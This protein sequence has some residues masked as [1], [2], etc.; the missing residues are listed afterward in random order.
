NTV[1]LSSGPIF[2]LLAHPSRVACNVPEPTNTFPAM[3]IMVLST[4]REES[5]MMKCFT[6]WSCL[7][8]A[9][10]APLAFAA[11]KGLVGVTLTEAEIVQVLH[12][13]NTAEIKAAEN[14]KAK[15]TSDGVKQFADMIIK[16]HTAMD[17]KVTE[18]EQKL[19]LKPA[20]SALSTMLETKANTA[21]AGLQ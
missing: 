21:I 14:A 4:Y 3:P 13:V 6:R 5:I 18:L 16:D 9:L 10:C 17:R 20:E 2:P 12:V 1:A 11:D 19:G 8:L 15:A 7:L